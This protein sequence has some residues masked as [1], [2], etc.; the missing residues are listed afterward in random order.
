MGVMS[1]TVPGDLTRQLRL[2]S[3]GNDEA[4]AR[5]FELA[6]DQ[7]R[8][9]AASAFRPGNSPTLQPTALVHEAWLALIDQRNQDWRSR[10]HFLAIA[11]R[12]MRRILVH[13]AEE[14]RAIKRGEG[15]AHATFV[16]ATDGLNRDQVDLLALNE[17]LEALGARDE[18][19]ARLVE[20]RFFA[21][22][23]HREIAEALGVTE[24]TVERDWR[25]ARA[26]LARAL[27]G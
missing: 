14:R 12:L 4:A 3:F 18:R 25:L 1:P 6:Y 5:V 21:G 13:H 2:Y 20:M 10:A 22:L 8:S 23:S 15:V 24:R 26:F 9:L 17:A 16:D 27:D 7:L 11:S 19:K